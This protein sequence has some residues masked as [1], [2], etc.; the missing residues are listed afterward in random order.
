[1]LR[2]GREFQERLGLSEKEKEKEQA[3]EKKKE[4]KGEGKNRWRNLDGKS[5]RKGLCQIFLMSD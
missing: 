4:Q 5:R 3:K 2:I 1:M